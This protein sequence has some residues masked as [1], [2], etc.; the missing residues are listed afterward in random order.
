MSLGPLMIDLKG[1]TI[2]AEEREWLQAPAVGGVVLFAR[3]F[4]DREQLEQL[5][6][7]I[8]G[9]RSPPLLVTVDQ[10]GGRVQRFRAPFTELPAPRQLGRLYDKD[11]E[12]ALAAAKAFGWLMA[13][14][15]RAVDI[16]MSFA[17]V[18]D[19]DRGLAKVIGDRAMYPEAEVVSRLAQRFAQG[20]Q[21]A[22]MAITAKHF[23]THAG[24]KSDSHT[25]T[26]VDRREFADLFDDLQPYRRLIGSGLL[27]AV[28]V[29]HVSFPKVDPLPAGFSSWWIES[30]LRGELGFSGAVVSDDLSMAG[31]SVAGAVPERVRLSLEAGAD[32][33]LVCNAPHE[34]PGV[35]DALSGYVD[36][37]AQLRLMR[38]RGRQRMTWDALRE[39]HEWRKARQALAQLAARPE[40]ELEG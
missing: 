37:P 26:A 13:A 34:V 22:G 32:L 6:A 12:A 39:S 9:V 23:P 16:D 29:A 15:L 38:L 11:P 25:E 28:M 14:E 4:A 2:D 1:A 40:L 33:A 10:E 17:P 18:V 8:H 35:I 27:H 31:A 30:Q 5:V 36:P 3:N 21:Q 7:D 20:A 19:L 24:V